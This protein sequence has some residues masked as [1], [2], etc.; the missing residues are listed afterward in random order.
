[1]NIDEDGDG[2]PDKNIDRDGD[3]KVDIEV[4][5]D[6][7][8]DNHLQKVKTSDEALVTEMTTLAITSLLVAILALVYKRKED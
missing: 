4:Q 7:F 2:I 5:G 1:M 3:G 6:D 8:K